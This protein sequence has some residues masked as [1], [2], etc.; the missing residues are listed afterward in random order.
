[1][2]EIVAVGA[3]VWFVVSSLTTTIT[4]V[5]CHDYGGLGDGRDGGGGWYACGTKPWGL[6]TCRE[7]V[8]HFPSARYIDD[9]QSHRRSDAQ[10]W[11]WSSRNW[12]VFLESRLI[13]VTHKQ[14]R[15]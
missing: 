5:V 8:E 7:M 4:C 14:H 12:S 3:Y 11:V 1:M 9:I 15:Q 2:D 10:L 13:S 6:V